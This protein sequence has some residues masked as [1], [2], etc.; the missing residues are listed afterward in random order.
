VPCWNDLGRLLT[1]VQKDIKNPK[2]SLA[3]LIPQGIFL[4]GGF[5]ASQ[6]L[7]AR[8]EKAN[9]GIQV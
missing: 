9:P 7:K 1:S 8:L 3:D 5:G 4:V 6:Y 2:W